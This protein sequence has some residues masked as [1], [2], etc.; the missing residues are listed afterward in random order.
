[1]IIKEHTHSKY[2]HKLFL[3]YLFIIILLLT[4]ISMYKKQNSVCSP[5]LHH[6]FESIREQTKPLFM[7]SSSNFENSYLN[8][9]MIDGK[10]LLN[11][12]INTLIHTDTQVVNI[13]TLRSI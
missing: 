4:I 13:N 1:M 6:Y 3:L 11:I 12:I 7:S 10:M 8:R 9:I 5:L 2:K